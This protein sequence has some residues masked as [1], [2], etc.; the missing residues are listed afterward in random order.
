[1]KLLR[2]LLFTTA[3]I[4]F[5]VA[6]GP[7][8]MVIDVAPIT[9][10]SNV[11]KKNT[12]LTK[13]E[14][15]TWGFADLIQDTIPGM[16]VDRA[17]NEIIK[18][19]KGE[20]VIVAVIDS[21]IDIEHE[22]LK[23]VIWINKKEI[24]GNGIDDDENGYI[25]DLHG[26]NFLGDIVEEAMEYTR[27]IKKLRPK[28]E[29][30]DPTAIADLD[31]YKLYKDAVKDYEKEFSEAETSA[32]YFSQIIEGITPI[33]EALTKKFGTENY[34]AKQL[35]SFD[36][37]NED[38][39]MQVNMLSVMMQRSGSSVAEMLEGLQ[40]G[41][42][43]YQGRINSHFNLEEDFRSVLGDDLHDLSDAYYGNNQVSGPDP[44]KAD[45]KHG[46]HVGGIIGA[47][48]NNGIGMNGVA[49]NVELMVLRAVPDGD[50]YDKDIALAIR[51]AVDNGAK[52]I[53]TSFGK[54]FATNPEW[55]WDAIKYASDHDVLIVNAAGNDAYDLDTI[56]VYPNDIII[57]ENRVVGETFL[58]VGA[59]NFE[60]GENLLA[61]FSNY[62]KTHV[63]VFAP[64]VQIYSTTPLNEYEFLQGTSM[65]A[66]NVA[67]VA[68]LIRSH[69][70]K[71]SAKQVK[72][73]IMESG[74]QPEIDVALGGNS[75]NKIPFKEASKSGKMV[76]LYNA[77][78]MAE[79][80]SK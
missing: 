14:L 45:A 15:K 35:E 76:N 41:K 63:D 51:Y 61:N 80:L 1:M 8:K 47:T 44:K 73:V 5:L 68:A 3:S 39:Q 4:A 40:E 62:G 70:P 37:E 71:L 48:R 24:A 29:D 12:P 34:T 78:I 33:H 22:D 42:E 20:S 25:D 23:D 56:Q 7:S 59:L 79:R 49:D 69:F 6:C 2:N 60:Y 30:A 31:E 75:S 52:V 18:D 10:I 66:P 13:D 57:D 67:G 55:V 16:S 46:T 38:Q 43:Y 11:T 36:A 64:G 53:N 65:A 54:Y 27:I 72:Q 17:Y 19:Q 74:L 77:L 21:G 26:W 58:T 50:E 28:Y 9:D 32:R